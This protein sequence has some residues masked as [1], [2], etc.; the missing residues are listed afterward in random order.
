MP[1]ESEPWG[2]DV[3]FP[4]WLRR[5]LRRPVTIDNTSEG[6]HQ[7]REPEEPGVTVL[8]HVTRAR[9]HHKQLPK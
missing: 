3:R 8:Q 7:V 1:R 6:T 9:T 5:V 4:R 2:G